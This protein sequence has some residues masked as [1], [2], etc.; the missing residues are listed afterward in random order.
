MLDVAINY[1]CQVR[2]RLR[3]VWFKEKY[4]YWNA[5]SYYQ[6][7]SL[8]DG[9]WTEH[10][11]VSVRDGIV[12]GYISY[13]IDRADGDVVHSLNIIN[14]EE[15]PSGT[16]ALDCGHAIR[17]IFEK[18]RFRKLN[19]FVIIGNPIEKTYDK[20]I[21]RYGGRIVG[22]KK[23]NARLIDG[24][25]YDEKLYEIMR[26]DYMEAVNEEKRTRDRSQR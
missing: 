8:A 2:E 25:Y 17:N 4:K 23:K 6:D 1:E 11:F 7:W 12:I 15:R 24:K 5:T 16:F 13:C 18:Y 26:D 21:D 9:T 3:S 20:M 19:F 22:I 10:Q 14:F